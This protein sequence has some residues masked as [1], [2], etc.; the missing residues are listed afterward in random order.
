MGAIYVVLIN[1]HYKTIDDAI[2]PL[3]YPSRL[4]DRESWHESSEYARRTAE[5]FP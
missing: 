1:I 5:L 2:A 4:P 3:H